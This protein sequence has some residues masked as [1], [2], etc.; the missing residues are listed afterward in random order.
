[1]KENNIRLRLLI[2]SSVKDIFQYTLLTI[3]PSSNACDRYGI[4]SYDMI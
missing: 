3:D 2:A 1:M 4:T